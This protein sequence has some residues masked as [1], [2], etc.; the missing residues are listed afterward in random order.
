MRILTVLFAALHL[1][2][3][4]RP[5]TPEFPPLAV[6]LIGTWSGGGT[7]TGRASSVTM[8]WERVIGE[9]F[10]RLRFRNAMAASATRPAEVFE[11]HGYYRV[12]PSGGTGTWF[13]SR[14]LTLPVAVGLSEDSWTSEWGSE[15]TERGR[16]VYR[17]AGTDA[18]EVVD[19]VRAPDGRSV[20]FGR[21]NLIRQGR[22]R[23]S[24]AGP[25]G[26]AALTLRVHPSGR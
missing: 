13:D 16:T 18:I 20:E 8:T 1:A 24:A 7:V 11:A 15:T 23:E 6:Q 21:T 17:L 14:G 10:L 12:G 4:P 9:A 5:A 26:L 2:Q 19:S 3:S 22:D 25:I